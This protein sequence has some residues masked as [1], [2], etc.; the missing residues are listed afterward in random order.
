VNGPGDVVHDQVRR[1]LVQGRSLFDYADDLAVV[2]PASCRSTGRCHECVV[3]I[4][5]GAEALSDR[6]PAEAYLTG[7]YRLA[8]QAVVERTSPDVEFAVLRRRLKILMPGGEPPAE[9]DPPVE[10]V[11]DQV[12][13]EGV[14][15]DTRRD[16][17]FGLAVDL[18][19]TTVVLELVDLRTGATVAVGAFENPQRFGGSD[20]MT[21]ISYDA[22]HPGELRHA[23]R[24]ALNHELRR[25]YEESGV[26]RQ[27]VYEVVIVG[28]STMRDVFFGLDVGPIGRSPYRSVSEAEMRAGR[29]ESTG[30]LRLAHE[31]GILVHPRARIVGAPLIASHVGADAAADLVAVDAEDAN[32]VVM[33]I[34]IGTNTEVMIGDGRRFLAASCP[35]GPAFEGG[36]VRYGMP[37]TEGAIEAI[38][39][40]SDRFEYR[41][42]GDVEPEGI[43]GSGLVDLLAEL[44]R[45]G[46][47]APDGVL[48]DG[49]RTVTVVPER[50]ITLSREDIS[51]LAQAKAANAAGQRVLLRTL[52]VTAEQVDRVYLAG[53]FAN[54]I[55]VTNAIDIGLLVPVPPERVVRVGNASVRGAK[56][57]LL[58]KRRRAR[59]ERHIRRIEH[60]ELEAEPDFFDLFVDGCRFERSAA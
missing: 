4:L 3:E 45:A 53:A 28:N 34:D 40:L 58:S 18:G 7:R 59:I 22:E 44:R 23:V 41:T 27:S 29:R 6:T 32:G 10:V 31:L 49:S 42:I 47:M 36:L 57:L 19:T 14:V 17:I 2:V 38:R 60:V 5:A 30:L 37:G 50:G 1:Q 21:R 55:D 16:G 8:C 56:A 25:I 51:H 43:C 24:K 46:R 20:V 15:L 12:T 52:G 9:I 33:V 13:Y 48:A 54:S 26:M 39:L 11:R 35:A